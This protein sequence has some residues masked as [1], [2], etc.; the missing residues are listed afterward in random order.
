M[1]DLDDCLEVAVVSTTN[2][3]HRPQPWLRINTRTRLGCERS[4]EAKIWLLLTFTP[5]L[6]LRIEVKPKSWLRSA[7]GQMIMLASASTRKRTF[8]ADKRREFIKKTNGKTC[9]FTTKCKVKKVVA[10]NGKYHSGRTPASMWSTALPAKYCGKLM[11][12]ATATR[13]NDH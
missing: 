5:L 13:Q 11:Q 4:S 12:N 3:W 9:Q 7:L 6:W 2:L 10:P 1:F 8:D